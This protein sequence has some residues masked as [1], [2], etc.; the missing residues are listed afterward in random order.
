MLPITSL[1]WLTFY[2]CVS[3]FETRWIE[4]QTWIVKGD[5]FTSY[6]INKIIKYESR[7]NEHTIKIFHR[8][9]EIFEVTIALHGFHMDKGNNIQIVMLKKWTCTCNKWQSFGIRCSH[10]LIVCARA[11]INSWQFVDKHYRMDVYGCC[12]TPQFNPIPH[13]SYWLEPYFPIVYPNL[14]LVRDKGRLK[15]SRIR[16]EI[17]WREP[18]VKFRCALCK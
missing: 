18:S 5:L 6:A 1:V 2:H 9:N 4:I 16:N 14:T 17:D 15:S 7:A 8:S 3:Y 10:V 12:Y 13:Q 11:K